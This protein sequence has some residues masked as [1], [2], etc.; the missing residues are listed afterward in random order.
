M[1]TSLRGCAVVLP[2]QASSVSARDCLGRL[3]GSVGIQYGIRDSLSAVAAGPASSS[4]CRWSLCSH[5]T[6]TASIAAPSP[7]HPSLCVARRRW[8][9]KP[10]RWLTAAMREAAHLVA[11]LD[12]SRQPSSALQTKPEL[13]DASRLAT[14]GAVAPRRFVVVACGHVDGGDQDGAGG[15]LE[16]CMRDADSAVHSPP[17]WRTTVAGVACR[18]TVSERP[19]NAALPVA[20]IA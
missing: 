16:R 15:G 19:A 3:A 12:I 14:I 5:S 2:G 1:S 4:A 9:A 13:V 17:T 7:A 11:L 20:D 8:S 18:L 10:R 6:M